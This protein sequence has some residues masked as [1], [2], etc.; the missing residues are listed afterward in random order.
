MFIHL[1]LSHCQLQYNL[2]ILCLFRVSYTVYICLKIRDFGDRFTEYLKGD[3]EKVPSTP[4]FI[5]YNCS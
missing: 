5:W 2:F 3:L 4:N 1:F